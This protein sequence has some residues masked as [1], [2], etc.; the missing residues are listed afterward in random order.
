MAECKHE[1]NITKNER[2]ALFSPVGC[3]KCGAYM[4]TVVRNVD[5]YEDLQHS[6]IDAADWARKVERLNAPA[7]K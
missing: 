1:P 6:P 4:G 7:S 5:G 2:I 3:R